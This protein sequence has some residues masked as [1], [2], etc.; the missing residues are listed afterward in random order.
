MSI[1]ACGL[2][3]PLYSPTCSLLGVLRNLRVGFHPS[4]PP[5]RQPISAGYAAVRLFGLLQS[6]SPFHGHPNALQLGRIDRGV[7]ISAQVSLL[8]CFPP[9]VD[10]RGPYATFVATEV[11]KYDP[12]GATANVV[13][14]GKG[15]LP[16]F[17]HALQWGLPW[18]EHV[19]PSSLPF[20]LLSP[21]QGGQGPVSSLW[22]F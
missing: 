14:R 19:S 7:C 4:L 17:Y 10:S 12:M 1:G 8:H 3:R 9:G 16:V 2:D 11:S 20:I 5:T 15:C 22:C 18:S 6:I 21:L 13:V